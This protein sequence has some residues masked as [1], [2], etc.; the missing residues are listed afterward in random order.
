[1]PAGVY[2]VS[3]RAGSTVAGARVSVVR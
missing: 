3:A 2:W 1:V